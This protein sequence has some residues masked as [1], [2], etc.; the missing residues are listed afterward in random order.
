MQEEKDLSYFKEQKFTWKNE[1]KK[2]WRKIEEATKLL[3]TLED[4]YIREKKRYEEADR[5][6]AMLDGRYEVLPPMGEG[7]EQITKPKEVTLTLEQIQKI[8][9]TLGVNITLPEG[10]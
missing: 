10:D 8:A 9:D 7:K 3:R 1:A 6:L 2:T 4:R 5:S